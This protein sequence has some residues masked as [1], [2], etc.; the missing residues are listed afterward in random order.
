MR[1]TLSIVTAA[2]TLAAVAL[3]AG[4]GSSSGS[5]AGA[6]TTTESAATTAPDTSDATTTAPAATAPAATTP[7]APAATA[8][9]VTVTLGA[10]TEF[11]LAASPAEVPAGKVAFTVANKGEILHEMVVVPGAGAAALTQPDGSASEEG[12]PG[13][14]PDVPPGEGGTVT[15]DLPAGD[16][17]LLCNLPGHFAG[18][19]YTTFVVT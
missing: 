1:R 4:C 15:I 8:S 3:A 7:A 18:G 10:P 2:A 14:V 9:T 11:A 6:G 17:V 13:E 16:Y 5:G 19:M 12:S